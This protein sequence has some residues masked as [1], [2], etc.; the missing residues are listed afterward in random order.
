M[1]LGIALSAANTFTVQ[2]RSDQVP[3]GQED[4][5]ADELTAATLDTNQVVVKDTAVNVTPSFGDAL[6]QATAGGT[7]AGAT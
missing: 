3:I 1:L 7:G 4:V 2:K 5:A 6:V